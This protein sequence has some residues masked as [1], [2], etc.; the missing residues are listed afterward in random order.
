[1]FLGALVSPARA[2]EPKVPVPTVVKSESAPD[3]DA[4]FA[5]KEGWIGGDG[6]YTAELGP[7]RVLWLFSDSLVGKVKGTKRTGATMVNNTLAVQN[8]HT[9]QASLRFVVAK[10]KEGKPAA[11]F[12]PTEGKGWF[13]PWA[14]IR[15][16]GRLFVFAPRYEKTKDG[17]A[18]GFKRLDVWLLVVA[19]PDDDPEKWHSTQH[20]VPFAST[21]P[22]RELS[23]G[24]AVME[25]DGFLFVYGYEQQHRAFGKR[26]MIVARVPADKLDDFT[27][28]EFRSANGWSKSAD[29]FSS[30]GGRV[31]DR[32][33]RLQAPGGKGFVAVYT[34]GGLNTRIV[35]RFA[36]EPEG[37]WS[38]RCSFT[39]VPR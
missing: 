36:A 1:M 15:V 22:D 13:W 23:W 16:R 21:A 5:V 20:K 18:F 26:S 39:P 19:N 38:R 29:R 17:G 28:W 12:T 35:G 31:G 25:K 11:F 6:L 27:A 24:S 8:G 32:V 37:P 4:K 34:D 10:G 2:E 7:E 9:P 30:P 14:A 33:L 3:W